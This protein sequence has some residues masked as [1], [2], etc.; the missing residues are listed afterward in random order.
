MRTE[1]LT[2]RTG[3]RPVVEDITA[4]HRATT[5]ALIEREL[6]ALFGDAVR[7]EVRLTTEFTRGRTGKLR[8]VVSKVPSSLQ[9]YA[10]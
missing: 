9:N 4:E 1:V 3:S 7:L 8:S 2:I 10:A 6:G 5:P